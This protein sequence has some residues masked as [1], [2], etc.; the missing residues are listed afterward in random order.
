MMDYKDIFYFSVAGESNSGKTELVEKMI[1]ELKS[2]DYKVATLKHTTGDYS[3]DEE[4]KDTWRHKKAGSD[5]VIFSTPSETSFLYDKEL[6]LENVFEESDIEDK[7][8]VLIIEGM[9]NIDIPKV[10]IGDLDSNYDFL[11][12]D[13]LDDIIEWIEENIEITNILEDL[14]QID[15]QECGYNTCREFAETVYQ[16]DKTIKDC[17]TLQQN[18]ITLKVNNENIPLSGFPA[19]IIKSSIIG[20]TETLKGVDEIDRLD[21][22]INN[23]EDT[24]E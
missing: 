17:V 18:Q 2:K 10:V 22:S 9:K 8:D 20:M 6:D 13:N 19:N 11:Y 21:I 12:D 14:P 7:Y 15:C 5:L 24:D 4:G 16:G 1:K 3:I 23:L